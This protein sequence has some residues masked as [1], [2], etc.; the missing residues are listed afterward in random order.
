M[1]ALP[2]I[3]LWDEEA[4]STGVLHYHAESDSYFWAPEFDPGDGLCQD[5]T[6]NMFHKA[7]ANDVDRWEQMRLE[8][9]DAAIAILRP[10]GEA[11]PSNEAKLQVS[12]GGKSAAPGEELISQ[13]WP[14]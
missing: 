9:R 1:S 12:S 14:S 11:A 13:F 3:L 6:D 5:V 8:K 2:D 10:S 4:P 7:R